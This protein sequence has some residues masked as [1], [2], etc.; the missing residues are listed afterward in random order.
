MK[1]ITVSIIIRTHNN[2]DTVRKAVESAL[3]QVVESLNVEVVLIDDASRDESF[4]EIADYLDQVS[5]IKTNGLGAVAALN[6]GI[7]RA[8]GQYFTILDADDFLPSNAVRSL[9]NP[10]LKEENIAAVYGDYYEIAVGSKSKKL[11]KTSQNIFN[12]V[13]GGILFKKKLVASSGLYDTSLFFPEYDLL[14]KLERKYKL[15]HVNKVVY[16]YVR[17][18]QS[19][20]ASAQKVIEGVKQLEKKYGKKLPI[21]EY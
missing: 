2:R 18:G 3:N 17:S 1:T 7:V 9:I 16:N 12:T 15:V 11:K 6:L 5:Y 14:I 4:E 20:T 19:L 10:F 21:R 8:T 13:A